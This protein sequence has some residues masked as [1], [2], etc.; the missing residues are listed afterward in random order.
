MTNN[1]KEDNIIGINK[2][3]FAIADG[4]KLEK[5]GNIFKYFDMRNKEI[6]GVIIRLIKRRCFFRSLLQRWHN[7]Y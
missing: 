1:K 3:W 2:L 7:C 4:S 5:V 6:R